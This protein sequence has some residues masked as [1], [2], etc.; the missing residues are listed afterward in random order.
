MN[1]VKVELK[2]GIALAMLVACVELVCGCVDSFGSGQF[3]SDI[4]YTG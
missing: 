3:Q 2:V 1:T 4:V